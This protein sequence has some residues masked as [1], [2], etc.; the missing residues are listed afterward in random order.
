MSM[1]TMTKERLA[2]LHAPVAYFIGGPSDIAHPNAADD[3]QR[4]NQVP[5]LLANRN[6]GH[7]PA[8]YR[9]PNGGAF[10]VAGVAWL[11]WR[12]EGDQAA[13]RMFVGEACGLCTDAAWTVERK[14]LR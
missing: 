6:V 13:S 4:I 1:V 12:L 2:E 8:T 14:D 11:K 10:A 3:F 5:V 9:E 7:Y